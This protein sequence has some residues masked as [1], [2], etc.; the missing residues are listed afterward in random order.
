MD[1][2]DLQ[3]LDP[4]QALA[5]AILARAFDDAVCTNG[6]KAAQELGLPPGVGLADDA[7]HF[8]AGDGARLLWSLLDLDPGEFDRR[9]AMLPRATCF[10][11]A[12]FYFEDPWP[13]PG[14]G[15]PRKARL[16]SGAPG[17]AK[18]RATS[19]RSRPSAGAR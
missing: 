9:V 6:H 2:A 14:R 12:L 16:A 15:R 4:W 3:G 18:P 5:C 11:P 1:P 19:P 17:Q 13:A 7:R 8:L 10:Q